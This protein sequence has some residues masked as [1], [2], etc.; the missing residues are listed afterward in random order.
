MIRDSW[1]SV[2]SKSQESY[3]WGSWIDDAY[4]FPNSVT[5][6]QSEGNISVGPPLSISSSFANCFKTQMLPVVWQ[7]NALPPIVL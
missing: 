4:Q 6:A 5:S 3:V 2:S 7:M 1:M